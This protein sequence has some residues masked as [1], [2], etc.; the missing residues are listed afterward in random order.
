LTGDPNST[1]LEISC[2]TPYRSISD[3]ERLLHK[4]FPT[5]LSSKISKRPQEVKGS[6]A[7][8]FDVENR[9]LQDFLDEYHHLLK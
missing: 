2:D 6:K 9:A 8:V 7:A 4:L 3:V 5:S 1:T